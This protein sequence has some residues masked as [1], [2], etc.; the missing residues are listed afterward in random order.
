MVKKDITVIFVGNNLKDLNDPNAYSFNTILVKDSYSLFSLLEKD[1]SNLKKYVVFL[2]FEKGKDLESFIIQTEENL[3]CIFETV[4][5]I[6]SV[7]DIDYID[8]D[9]ISKIDYIISP[10]LDKCKIENIILIVYSKKK[11]LVDAKKQ[12]LINR[13]IATE[14]FEKLRDVTRNSLEGIKGIPELYYSV[15][16]NGI[17]QTVN[18]EILHILGF[19]KEE[20]IGRHFKEIIA[21]EE[22]Q[23]IKRAFNERRTGDRKAR[24]T[25]VKFKTKAGGYEEFIIDAQGIHEPSVRQEPEKDQK[26]VYIGTFGEGRRKN[27]IDVFKSTYEPVV[28]YDNTDKKLFINEAF[29]SLSGY[30]TDEVCDKSPAFFEKE[31]K[32]FFDSCLKNLKNKKHSSYNTQIICKSGEKKF[33]EASFDLLSFD[34]RECIIGVYRDISNIL[35]ILREAEKIIY[36][37]WI[38][39]N[40]S[41]IKGI[42]ETS[43]QEI[44]D[45][46]SVPFVA[47]GMF[48]QKVVSDRQYYVKTNKDKRWITANDIDFN[49]ILE[50]FTEESISEKKTV[51]KTITNPTDLKGL[52]AFLD[53]DTD[54]ISVSS[55]LIVNNNVI[56]CIVI[57]HKRDSDFT[58]KGVRLIELTTNVVANGIQRLKLENELHDNLENL[59]V[60]VKERTKELEDFT[61]TISHDL[62]SPLHAARG[63]AAMVKKR[64]LP[65]IKSDEDNYILRRIEENISQ[66]IIMINDLLKLS[67]LGTKELKFESI[68]LE[69]IVKSYFLQFNALNSDNLNIILKKKK[70]LP[71]INADK[72]RITQLFTNIFDNAIK[73]RKFSDVEIYIDSEVKSNKVFIQIKDNGIGIDQ[74]DIPNLFKI[75]YRGKNT[76]AEGSGVGLTVVKK[77]VEQHK[78]NVN[79]FSKLNEGTTVVFELPLNM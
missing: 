77:I 4:P 40:S 19:S 2:Y 16:E 5:V 53:N 42:V 36:L 51:Y 31:G 37:S 21:Q 15:D 44:S 39:G 47:V 49:K 34:N 23:D 56:G 67:R 6:A 78:G 73:H 61:Y 48:N 72:G 75:F 58:L 30:K 18:D 76:Q 3:P 12:Y 43:A 38:I 46:I 17:I 45:I 9:K 27:Y 64:F 13:A 66:A 8:I 26:R 52:N 60:R 32:S 29:T 54:Y 7:K 35:E 57:L 74:N 24:D 70:K 28:V 62:K 22:F 63:F 20:I 50:L 1:I 10:P 68:D 65:D 25:V 55:P 79:I 69:D 41:T 71:V 59:E 33:V 11:K 14:L